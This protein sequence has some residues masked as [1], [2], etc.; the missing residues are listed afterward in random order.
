MNLNSFLCRF[1]TVFC[2][3]IRILDQVSQIRRFH[4]ISF[5][6]Q[7]FEN[8]PFP[9]LSKFFVPKHNTRTMVRCFSKC[10]QRF[11]ASCRFSSPDSA[12]PWP[13]TRLYKTILS[14]T[15]SCIYFFAREGQNQI[16]IRSERPR[17]YSFT[18]CYVCFALSILST[19]YVI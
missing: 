7:R 16:T 14:V 19:Y 18:F 4:W 3:C 17:V 5:E 12:L 8:R 6:F 10:S 15:F 2:K 9:N 11:R 1:P 13:G